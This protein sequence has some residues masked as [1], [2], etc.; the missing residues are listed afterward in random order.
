MGQTQARLDL[1]EKLV[2]AQTQVTELR[3]RLSQEHSFQSLLADSQSQAA[4]LESAKHQRL[5]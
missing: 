2:S 3:E 1:S 4:Q 5:M